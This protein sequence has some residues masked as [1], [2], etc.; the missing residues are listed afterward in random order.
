[1]N[2]SEVK[3]N[4][5]CKVKEIEIEEY[6]T[7]LRLMELG[8]IKNA[9]IMVKKKSLMKKTLLV[10]FS[11]SCFTINDEMSSKIMVEYA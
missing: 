3:L 10:V 7:K 4:V 11:N 5:W 8:I 9:K 2:L 1:M 6:K